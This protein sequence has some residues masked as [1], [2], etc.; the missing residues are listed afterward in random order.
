MNARDKPRKKPHMR[1]HDLQAQFIRSLRDP[2]YA[3]PAELGSFTG[4]A[5]NKRFNVYRNNV[6]VSLTDNLAASYPVV[7]QLVGDEFFT[8]MARVFVDH[9]APTSAV[10][11]HYGDGF[12]EFVAAFEPA[13]GLPFLADVARVERGWNQTYN[14]ADEEPISI[15]V[16]Q[17]IAAD[18]LES[19]VLRLHPSLRIVRS[20]WPVF[21]IWHLHKS[22]DDPTAAMQ[23]LSPEAQSGLIVRPRLDVD[24]RII[25]DLASAFYLALHDGQS[26]G[27]AAE[28]LAEAQSD[29]MGAMLQMLF[30]CGAV[31]R[32]DI[33]TDD[34]VKPMSM[35][36]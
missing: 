28:P 11:L 29:E 25:P 14:A 20:D 35:D 30:A 19:A 34:D 24:V 17:T 3:I 31:C 4:T 18:E 10:M 9:N 22:T 32:V 2:E 23:D 6:A 12:P 7:K 33:A 16:L 26:L 15:D 13:K 21:S 5:S 1:W 36:G 27:A 8:G